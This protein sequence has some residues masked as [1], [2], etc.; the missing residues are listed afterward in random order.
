MVYRI[1]LLDLDHTLIDTDSSIRLAFADAMKVAETDEPGAYETFT[2]INAALWKQVER[3]EITPQRVNL[4][5]FEQ[6]AHELGLSASPADMATAF[7]AGM[8]EHGDLYGG[9]RQL[10]DDLSA[11]AVLGLITNGLSGIQ[12]RR[13]ERLELA[14]YFTVVVI[15]EEAG[16]A[17]PSPEIF[18]LALDQLASPARSEVL[19]VGDSLSSDIAGGS[20]ADIDTCWY[21]PRGA[22][23]PTTG[24]PTHIISSLGELPA[25]VSNGR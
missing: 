13:I 19:M 18:D 17:K 15:S 10:L 8:G 23:V 11:G 2:E 22:L 9:A 16:V 12:R 20:A 3:Q 5:R 7:A 1:V 21:N 24:Q 4:A 14:Q 25:V 6:F